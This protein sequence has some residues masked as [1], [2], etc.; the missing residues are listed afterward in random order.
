VII[1]NQ[2]KAEFSAEEALFLGEV[3]ARSEES[4]ALD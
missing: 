3:F 1:A 2:Q 4:A